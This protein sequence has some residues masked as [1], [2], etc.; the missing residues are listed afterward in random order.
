MRAVGVSAASQ[1]SKDAQCGRNGQDVTQMP[2]A[3]GGDGRWL[4]LRFT[5]VRADVTRSC[6]DGKHHVVAKNLGHPTVKTF[7]THADNITTLSSPW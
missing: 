5:A 2:E 3:N 4:E 7:E 1:K 6:R